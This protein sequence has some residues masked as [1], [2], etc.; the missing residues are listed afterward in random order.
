MAMDLLK[1]KISDF[2]II[3]LSFE[4]S[5]QGHNLTGELIKSFETTIREQGDV[6]TIDFLML[7]YGR[8]LNDGIRPEKI[9]FTP[10]P[11]YR[12]GTSKYIEGLIKF[13]QLKFFVDKKEATSIA[14]A[15]ANKHKRYGYPLTGKTHFIDIAIDANSE[16]IVKLIQDYYEA[17]IELLI[18]KFIKQ[19]A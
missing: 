3:Q 11:P 9:P 5:R 12:G 2:V 18:T 7:K 14:F 17:T 13:A 16:N 4:L 10:V 1:K 15:I 19:I 8:S 6:I